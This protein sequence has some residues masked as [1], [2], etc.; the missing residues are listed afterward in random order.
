[1]AM[2]T[3]RDSF[4]IKGK[5]FFI[6]DKVI[7]EGR[8]TFPQR[9]KLARIK[10]AIRI[11]AFYRGSSVRRDLMRHL[12]ALESDRQQRWESKV[13]SF[14]QERAARVIQRA[15]RRML[16][17]PLLAKPSTMRRIAM[18]LAEPVH[19]VDLSD[20]LRPE[21]CDSPGDEFEPVSFNVSTASADE[22]LD[23]VTHNDCFR[24][25]PAHYRQLS[26]ST[27]QASKLYDELH[28]S[29]MSFCKSMAFDEPSV[30]VEEKQFQI[31]TLC[32]LQL[33][34]LG[35]CYAVKSQELLEELETRDDLLTHREALRETI[36]TLLA[37]T[38]RR[39][40]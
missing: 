15:V 12:R 33:R 4:F 3:T 28:F 5:S 20:E 27:M 23:V 8:V 10:A 30:Q 39:R 34:V 36:A 13:L 16:R 31:E 14:R 9:I 6:D 2:S 22:A 25:L 35:K 18:R 26:I 29:R 17:L 19:F 7:K 32:D 38:S 21:Y 37:K 1:M 11:Q 40:G 24:L